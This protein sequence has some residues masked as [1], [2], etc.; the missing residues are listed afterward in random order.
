MYDFYSGNL[1][2]TFNTFFLPVNQ[3]TIIIPDLPQGHLTHF[4]RLELIMENIRYSG[5]KVW[6]E[7]DDETTKLK[8][9]K[10]KIKIKNHSVEQ[11]Y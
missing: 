8:Q 7:I 6:N 3:N 1:P 4:P 5:V 11:V 2:E 9:P 10:F